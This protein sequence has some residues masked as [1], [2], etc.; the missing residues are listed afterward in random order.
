M[1]DRPQSKKVSSFNLYVN[2]KHFVCR[3]G[4]NAD[5]LLTL[6]DAKEGVFIRLVFRPSCAHEHTDSPRSGP[7]NIQLFKDF[8]A[9][10]ILDDTPYRKDYI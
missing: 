8:E 3:I 2:V 5:I 9:K 4:E 7:L 1:F 10:I 6:Y